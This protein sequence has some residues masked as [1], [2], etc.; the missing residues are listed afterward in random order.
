MLI[1]LTWHVAFA[2]ASLHLHQLR[3][4]LESY[5]ELVQ[6]TNRS[7]VGLIRGN[8]G[9]FIQTDVTTERWTSRRP[10]YGRQDQITA[11]KVG[12]KV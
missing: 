5:V 8:D 1:L 12:A 9:K 2:L 7:I 3:L 4:R 6:I 11:R 10:D